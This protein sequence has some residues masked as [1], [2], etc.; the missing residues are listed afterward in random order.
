MKWTESFFCRF[1]MSAESTCQSANENQ[2]KFEYINVIL[3]VWNPQRFC[4]NKFSQNTLLLFFFV[5]LHSSC[6]LSLHCWRS[7]VIWTAISSIQPIHPIKMLDR[8]SW[9][10]H[11]YFFTT[12][13]VLSLRREPSQIHISPLSCSPNPNIHCTAWHFYMLIS[14]LRAYAGNMRGSRAVGWECWECI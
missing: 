1:F 7:Q 13:T 6:C 12:Q 2:N 4:I 14:V 10:L 11:C 9:K 5:I 8:N 3:I